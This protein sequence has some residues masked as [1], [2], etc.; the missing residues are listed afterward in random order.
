MV[1]V[2]APVLAAFAAAPQAV[3]AAEA[4]HHVKCQVTKNGKTETKTVATSEDCSAMGGKV[5][6]AKHKK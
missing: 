3:L 5:V 1:L 4:K 2:S 6:T